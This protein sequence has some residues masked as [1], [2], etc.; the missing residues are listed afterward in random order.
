MDIEELDIVAVFQEMGESYANSL[1]ALVKSM[2]N[3]ES[4]VRKPSGARDPLMGHVMDAI[5]SA[6]IGSTMAE[7]VEGLSFEHAELTGAIVGIYLGGAEHHSASMAML[8][9]TLALNAMEQRSPDWRGDEEELAE[10]VEV[11]ASSLALFLG[12]RSGMIE[13]VGSDSASIQDIMAGACGQ[14]VRVKGGIN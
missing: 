5:Y 9:M 11:V 2:G 3:P 6:P 8:Y 7:W 4:V 10:M 14:T 1:D 13:K 12:V